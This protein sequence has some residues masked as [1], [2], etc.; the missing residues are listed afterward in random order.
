MN[1]PEATLSALDRLLDITRVLRE[2]GGCDWDRAQDLFSM[3]EYLLEEAAEVID[4]VN[5]RDT[6]GLQEE[7]GDLLFIVFFLARLNEEAGRFTIREVAEGMSDKLIRRHPHVF[8][9]TRVDKVEDIVVNWEKIKEAEQAAKNGGN[10]ETTPSK[11]KSVLKD[12]KKFLPALSRA[13]KVQEKVA[14][15]GFDWPDTDGVFAK[16]REEIDELEAEVRAY[17]GG[18]NTEAVQDRLEDEAGDLLF[19]F[20]NVMRHLKVH[21]EAALHRSTEKFARRFRGV[22]DRLAQQGATPADST[23][24][25]MDRLWNE[26][27]A[28]ESEARTPGSTLERDA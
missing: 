15:V 20:V 6:P 14:A 13:Y 17:R 11:R 27:K 10:A 24:G 28:D 3:R 22:E 26:V 5:R 16:L 1:Q 8:G 23:L 21:P 9:D 18:Q 12:T 7:L 25:E 4:A 19:A 2:P